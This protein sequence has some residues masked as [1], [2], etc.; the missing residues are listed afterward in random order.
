MINELTGMENIVL[1]VAIQDCI[2]RLKE[3]YS[4]C[5]DRDIRH[6]QSILDM[7]KDI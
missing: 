3:L 5:Q 4:K 6:L 2:K 7:P 1:K